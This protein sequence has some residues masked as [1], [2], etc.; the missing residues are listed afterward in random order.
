MARVRVTQ[1]YAKRA[2]DVLAAIV[3]LLL[4]SPLLATISVAILVNSGRPVL[5]TQDRLGLHGRVFQIVK[6]RTMVVGAEQQGTGIRTSE[7]DT[8]VTRIGRLLRRTSMDELPQLVNVLRG[9][10]SLVGPR[11]PAMYHPYQ[12]EDYPAEFLPRFDMRPG[13]TGLAQTMGRNALSWPE[14]LSYDVKYVAQWGLMMDSKI[15][16]ATIAVVMKASGAVNA[17]TAESIQGGAQRDRR[18]AKQ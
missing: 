4:L 10:M 16:L 1:A 18:A 2:I 13:M 17:A 11:P 3:L 12:Y 9:D 14:R 6:F 8:R 5:F 15:L 7:A